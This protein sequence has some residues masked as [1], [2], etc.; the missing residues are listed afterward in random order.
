MM[1]LRHGIVMLKNL[2]VSAEIKMDWKHLPDGEF[3]PP[4]EMN[5]LEKHLVAKIKEHITMTDM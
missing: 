1:I 2:Q 5:V 4:W 3:L